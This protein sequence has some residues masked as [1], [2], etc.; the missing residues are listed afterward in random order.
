M[1]LKDNF[2]KIKDIFHQH[3]PQSKVGL[4]WGGKSETSYQLVKAGIQKYGK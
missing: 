1:T 2:K 4:S 3:A